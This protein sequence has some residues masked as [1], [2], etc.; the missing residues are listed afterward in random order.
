VEHAGK[1][2]MRAAED[3]PQ[4]VKRPEW[5]PIAK[6]DQ[7]E[8]AVVVLRGG[9]KRKPQGISR[10]VEQENRRAR[11]GLRNTLVLDPNR[12]LRELVGEASAENRLDVS[13]PRSRADSARARQARIMVACHH[14]AIEPE[15]YHQQESTPHRRTDVNSPRMAFVD[16]PGQGGS[17]AAQT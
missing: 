1:L 16:C 12:D 4:V 2:Q 6:N 3:V 5:S 13:Q 11:Q 17:I 15:T 9:R 8:P 7:V 14:V 10:R